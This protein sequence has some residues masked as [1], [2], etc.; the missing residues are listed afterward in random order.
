MS[1]G[2]S[3]IMAPE[4]I[5]VP[6]SQLRTT[7]SSC[8]L[9]FSKAFSGPLYSPPPP[10]VKIERLAYSDCLGNAAKIAGVGWRCESSY[11]SKSAPNWRCRMRFGPYT[12]LAGRGGRAIRHYWRSQLDWHFRTRCRYSTPLWPAPDPNARFS[13][14]TNYYYP[15]II[16]RVLRSGL[17]Q[18]PR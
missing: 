8:P 2:L 4:S 12:N 18:V 7:L 1:L 6:T 3:E 10:G 17:T 11:K 13:V 16:T 15:T 14:C 9:F 5:A